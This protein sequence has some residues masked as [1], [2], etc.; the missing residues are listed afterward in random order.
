MES[1]EILCIGGFILFF[2]GLIFLSVYSQRKTNAR[3]REAAACLGFTPVDKPGQEFVDRIQALYENASWKRFKLDHVSRK[4][5][6]DG[7][8][9]L[10]DLWETSGEDNTTLVEQGIAILSPYLHLPRFSLSPKLQMKGA[11]AEWTNSLIK[12]AYSR[13]DQPVDFSAH[14]AFDSRYI[15]M[16]DEAGAIRE[17]LDAHLMNRLLRLENYSVAAG[18]DVLILSH[19]G[20]TGGA[21]PAAPVDP[22]D[23]LGEAL[24]LYSWFASKP[25]GSNLP[26]ATPNRVEIKNCPH[27]GG[28]LAG[29][30]LTSGIL[31]CSYCGSQIDLTASSTPSQ[32]AAGEIDAS[33]TG[34]SMRSPIPLRAPTRADRNKNW[35]KPFSNSSG[36]MLPFG[37]VWTLFSAIFLV[38][39]VATYFTDQQKYSLLTQEGVTTRA[40][41]TDLQEVS[42][43]E[44]DTYYVY[45][46]Y[47]VPVAG[48]LSALSTRQSVPYPLYSRLEIGQEIEILYA[49]S[50]P[51]I[52]E[53][54]AT[55]GPPSVMLPVCFGGMGLLFVLIGLVMVFSGIAAIKDLVTHLVK[56]RRGNEP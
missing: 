20:F 9:Y 26:G 38:I 48:D 44:D 34:R 24:E 35:A 28:E 37:L 31:R 46:R 45:Y 7:E 6:A 15:V 16:G 17:C 3:K 29:S 25:S 10:F 11:L 42:D 41:I 12:W 53:I 4:S 55:F 56:R 30:M 27:C 40:A 32:K 18:G 2:V 49:A 54:K 43:S 19:S 33:P 1:L 5:F 22:K 39:G 47:T 21:K 14:P 23:T 8:I 50:N 52:A 36:C 13:R 51:N